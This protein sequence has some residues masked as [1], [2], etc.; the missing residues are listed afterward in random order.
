MI[1]HMIHFLDTREVTRTDARTMTDGSIQ[2]R[3]GAPITFEELGFIAWSEKVMSCRWSYFGHRARCDDDT[4]VNATV[5]WALNNTTIVVARERRETRWTRGRAVRMDEDLQKCVDT[6]P[7]SSTG[8][9]V[10]RSAIYGKGVRPHTLKLG[11]NVQ[12]DGQ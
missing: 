7:R 6:S 9:N 12:H 5:G 4:L 1:R 8:G 2:T 10:R 11:E 3:R